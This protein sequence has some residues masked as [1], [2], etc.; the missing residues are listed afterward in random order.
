MD[1]QLRSAYDNLDDKVQERTKELH[2]SNEALQTEVTERKRAEEKLE[3]E[4]NLLLAIFDGIDDV[5]YVADPKSYEL[6]HVNETFKQFWGKDVIG[7]KC[8]NVIQNRD[9]P[10]PFCTNDLIFGEYLGKT[11]IWEKQNE[12]NNVWFR[13][14][15]KA[16][17]WHD[18][19]MVRFELASNISKIKKTE[20]E[21]LQSKERITNIIENVND[22]VWEVDANAAYTYVSPHIE[23]LL[24]YKPEE[25]L[26]KTPFDLMDKGDI[27]RVSNEFG[28]I[29]AAKRGFTGLINT[30]VH[31]DGNLV[32]METNGTP[33]LDDEGNLLGFRGTDRDITERIK[34]EEQ[35]KQNSEALQRSNQELEQFAYVASHDLQEPLRS[36]SGFLQILE[37]RYK[38]KI[39][40]SGLHYIERS[41]AAATRMRDL[42][43]SLLE[44]SRVS[45][46][47][48]PFIPTDVNKVLKD[49]LRNLQANV[50]ETGAIITH[51]PL[52]T[53][54]VDAGQFVQLFQN[55]IANGI[56]FCGD[57]TPEIHIS[58]VTKDDDYV[59]SIKD[60][61]IGIEE[62]YAERIFV[63][64]QR[65]HTRADIPGTGIGLSISRRIIERHG[66]EIWLE[67]EPGQGTTFYFSIPKER[68]VDN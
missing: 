37:R 68:S 53:A 62:Q 3:E 22:W 11:Y 18:G 14:A 45:S 41:T 26:G 25:V 47:G 32:V 34:A 15:D 58:V 29:A 10:C 19:R 61:G 66:G 49:V 2:E 12:I 20:E 43:Q 60:N 30:N 55:L 52:P 13:L 23:S 50:E 6:L 64:F 5:I 63:I 48:N 42:I 17:R 57:K 9:E 21:L 16:I 38:D 54:S 67:S 1:K 27:E 39:G 8:Y 24:G 65:L 46:R 35:I 7:K 44:Y 4:R 36:V 51:D 56:K 28:E 40:E 59:F 31:K 33:I